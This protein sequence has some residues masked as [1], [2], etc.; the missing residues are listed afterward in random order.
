MRQKK[1]PRIARILRKEN[2]SP[3]L[4]RIIFG[5]DELSGFP[6]GYESANIKLLMPNP[7]QSAESYRD[8][9]AG[10][11]IKPLKRTYTVLEYREADKQLDVEFALHDNPGPATAWAIAAEPG[12]EMAIA[13]PG[14]LRP[15][16]LDADWFLLAG[17]M[18]AIP[19]IKAI[20][21]TL[22]QNANG[23]V[24]LEILTPE[25]KH[26]FKKPAGLEIEWVIN[27]KPHQEPETD[28]QQPL[29]RAFKNVPWRDGKPFVWVAGESNGVRSIRSYLA[30]ER[31]IAKVDRYC[32]G[33]WQRGY[34]EDSHQ[35]VKRQEPDI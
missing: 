14:Q 33:Y 32:S 9:L 15:V 16:N 30:N 8:S 19:A 17:D 23:L 28:D 12:D 6:G 20:A 4:L 3:N 31:A 27:P 11:G 24:L 1:P 5:G 2:T 21:A 7:G 26:A 13:G 10:T 22:P 34:N 35:L 29:V 18:S 25:D